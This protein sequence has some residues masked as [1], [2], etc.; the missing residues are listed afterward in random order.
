MQM[1]NA[2]IIDQLLPGIHSMASAQLCCPSS[3]Q[4]HRQGKGQGQRAAWRRVF[5]VLSPHPAQPTS[6]NKSS[7][8]RCWP[9]WPLGSSPSE[10]LASQPDL[11][12]RTQRPHSQPGQQCQKFSP[13]SAS[14]RK[15]FCFA[16]SL[17]KPA[18][19]LHDPTGVRMEFC[20]EMNKKKTIS[21]ATT[22]P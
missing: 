21:P 14:E 8:S 6:G 15:K 4:G 5:D 9:Q 3:P 10:T 1:P 17:S 12:T 2:N 16:S 7:F 13:D 22:H 20:N 19:C 11:C 18:L